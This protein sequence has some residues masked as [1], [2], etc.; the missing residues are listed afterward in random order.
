MRAIVADPTESSA[1]AILFDPI[2]PFQGYFLSPSSVLSGTKVYLSFPDTH[3]VILGR[4]HLLHHVGP[5]RVFPVDPNLWRYATVCEPF[6]ILPQFPTLS[7]TQL[8]LVAEPIALPAPNDF[9]IA[10]TRLLGRAI[11]KGRYVGRVVLKENTD[12]EEA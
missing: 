1:R 2:D 9:A 4:E 5:A 7:D 10:R 11:G 3:G 12:W 8:E 6:E